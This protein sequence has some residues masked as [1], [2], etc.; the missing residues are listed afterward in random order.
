M[1]YAQHVSQAMDLVLHALESTRPL[2]PQVVL[3]CD[4]CLG[5]LD[6][7]QPLEGTVVT[8]LGRWCRRCEEMG[9]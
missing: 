5:P 2:V 4:R 9:L 3:A 1:N 7:E 6:E 8:Q